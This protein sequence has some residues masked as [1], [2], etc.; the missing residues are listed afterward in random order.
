MKNLK[1]IIAIALACIMVL[2]IYIDTKPITNEPDANGMGWGGLENETEEEFRARSL[3]GKQYK[4]NQKYG[5]SEEKKQQYRDAQV[6]PDVLPGMWYTEAINAM[7]DGG[8]LNGYTDGLFH[9]DDYITQG[10]FAKILCEYQ[11]MEP[12][13]YTSI[14]TYD[15]WFHEGKHTLPVTAHWAMKY[16][17]DAAYGYCM[18]NICPVTLDEPLWRGDALTYVVRSFAYANPNYFYTYYYN[19]PLYQ[20]EKVW[21]LDDIPDASELEIGTQ[22][23][24]NGPLNKEDYEAHRHGHW[25]DAGAILGAYNIGATQGIDELGTCAPRQP[26]TRAELCQMLYN[27]GITKKGQADGYYNRRHSIFSTGIPVD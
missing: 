25:F 16:A 11:D 18:M 5:I 22:K 23:D 26:M 24:V 14:Y 19:E 9:P 12:V 8:L 1:T 13:E 10:Q 15:C 20:T 2:G 7:T 21:T 3:K 6:Y 4:Y 17:M 27:L